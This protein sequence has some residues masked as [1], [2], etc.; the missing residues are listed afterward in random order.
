MLNLISI[1][2]GFGINYLPISKRKVIFILT[3]FLSG[4]LL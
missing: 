1:L 4:A 3:E 2:I